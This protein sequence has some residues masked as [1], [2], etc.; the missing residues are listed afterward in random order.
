[1]FPYYPVS[2]AGYKSFHN[3]QRRIR[4][5]FHF[6][7][8]DDVRLVA[9]N[10]VFYPFDGQVVGFSFVLRNFNLLIIDFNYAKRQEISYGY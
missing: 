9:D 6:F 8:Y 7:G 4:R 1:M 10:V 2:S 3:I 5:I